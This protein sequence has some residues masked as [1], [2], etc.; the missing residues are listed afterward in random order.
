MSQNRQ[1]SNVRQQILKLLEHLER[2]AQAVQGK[3]SM[4]RGSLYQRR[5]KCGKPGCRCA[6]GR[7]HRTAALSVYRE[8]R[9]R[10]VSLKDINLDRLAECVDNY[11]GFRKTRAEIVTTCALLLKAVDRLGKLREIELRCFAHQEKSSI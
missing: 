9:S 10:P 5:C 7:L 3:S 8:G 4:V 2:L 11:R 6:K 1:A